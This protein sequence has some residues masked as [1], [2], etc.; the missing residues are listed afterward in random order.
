[1]GEES[2]DGQAAAEPKFISEENAKKARG[3]GSRT[4]GKLSGRLSGRLPSMSKRSNSRAKSGRMAGGG[5]KKSGMHRTDS[6]ASHNS[7]GSHRSG[8]HQSPRDTVLKLPRL[9]IV[10]YDMSQGW[11]Q[12]VFALPHNAIRQELID[13]Y[14]MLGAIYKRGTKTS[15]EED[16]HFS[17]WWVVF[18]AF[19]SEYFEV[20]KHI[21]MPL[22]GQAEDDPLHKQDIAV[23][24]SQLD[25]ARNKLTSHLQ[26]VS[27][28]VDKL[29]VQPMKELFGQLCQAL[30]DFVPLLLSYFNEEEDVLP[31]YIMG[32]HAANA[33]DTTNQKI[34]DH[35]LNGKNPQTNIVLL[36]AWMDNRDHLSQWKKK[37]LRG[38][39]KMQFSRWETKFNK[40]H[41]KI[42]A[43]FHN[44]V[45]TA[46][47]I[48]SSRLFGDNQKGNRGR[49][50]VLGRS[51]RLF[52]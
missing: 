5:S 45:L 16:E 34:A 48:R 27:E 50:S 49:A 39:A 15:R 40:T 36:V 3:K 29:F 4:S 51:S 52:G 19:L 10:D 8:K 9:Y 47:R 6:S 14:T 22:L 2:I 35:L 24:I 25:G 33:K 28:V 12:D 23:L 44:T 38:F 17:E 13:L 37:A 43:D 41:K 7:R 11:A 18:A 21:L 31:A 20:E 32:Y 30:D 26:T 42:I 46:S 1:M